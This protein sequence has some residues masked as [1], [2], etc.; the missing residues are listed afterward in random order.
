MEVQAGIGGLRA[1]T[2]EMMETPLRFP[3]FWSL[4][5]VNIVVLQNNRIGKWSV[6]TPPVMAATNQFLYPVSL[7]ISGLLLPPRVIRHVVRNSEGMTSIHMNTNT[8]F[9]RHAHFHR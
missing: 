6:L 1:N 7:A 8:E 9:N 5:S 2:S 3:A 4:F